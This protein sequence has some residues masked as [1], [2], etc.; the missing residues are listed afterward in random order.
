MC[1]TSSRRTCRTCTVRATSS[2]SAA[3]PVRQIPKRCTSRRHSRHSRRRSSH[4][5]TRSRSVRL[6]HRMRRGG[7]EQTRVRCMIR[8]V[9]LPRL[10]KR[11][12]NPAR[13]WKPNLRPH[14][15]L[16][17]NPRRHGAHAFCLC[18]VRRHARGRHRRT[19]CRNAVWRSCSSR[20]AAMLSKQ[21]LAGSTSH[22]RRH[23]R[24]RRRPSL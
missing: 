8:R 15:S 10:P 2:G 17:R 14:Y 16:P 13:P 6:N 24:R 1:W 12:S 23:H 11:P 7:M 21:T 19:R 4:T 5:G 9:I 20:R 22:R 3:L 18:C